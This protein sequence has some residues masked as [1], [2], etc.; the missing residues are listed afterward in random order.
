MVIWY[1]AFSIQRPPESMPTTEESAILKWKWEN[2]KLRQTL[3]IHVKVTIYYCV[4]YTGNENRGRVK[5]YCK[6]Q[7]PS[8]MMPYYFVLQECYRQELKN[9]V[10]E[11]VGGEIFC[12]NAPEFSFKPK[13]LASSLLIIQKARWQRK[14]AYC[15]FCSIHKPCGTV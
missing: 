9:I 14:Q 13:L 15:Q 6:K 4:S 7:N 1:F 8:G 5:Y 11:Q 12:R 10:Q 2:G 3:K